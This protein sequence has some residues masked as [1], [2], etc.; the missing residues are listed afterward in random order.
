M[1]AITCATTAV[2]AVTSLTGTE[3]R[4]IFGVVNNG[5]AFG[6]APSEDQPRPTSLQCQ[7]FQF[8]CA[9]LGIHFPTGAKKKA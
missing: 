4:E 2:G 6:K 3:L 7:R 5:A 8:E 1:V 9:N